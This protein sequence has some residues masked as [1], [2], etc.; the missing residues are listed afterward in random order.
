MVRTFFKEKPREWFRGYI[1]KKECYTM[2]EETELEFNEDEVE[3]FIYP[4]LAEENSNDCGMR[5]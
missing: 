4:M 5:W 2:H 1:K 3:A